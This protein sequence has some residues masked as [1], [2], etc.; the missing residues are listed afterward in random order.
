MA[1][2]KKQFREL[3][4]EELEKVT[5]GIVVLAPGKQFTDIEL[6]KMKNASGQCIENGSI[7]VS[8]ILKKDLL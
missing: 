7:N 2:E 4:D 1:K 6:C 8:S 3:S 5:G